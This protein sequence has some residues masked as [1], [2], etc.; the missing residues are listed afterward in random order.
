V[1]SLLNISA[2]SASRYDVREPAS[3]DVLHSR[4]LT[5]DTSSDLG[6][7]LHQVDMLN[8][9]EVSLGGTCCLPE[10]AACPENKVSENTAETI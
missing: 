7:L 8:V 6:R 9:V 3:A 5:I 1:T 4:L 10:D 2:K